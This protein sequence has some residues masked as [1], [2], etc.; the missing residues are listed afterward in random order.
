VRCEFTKNQFKQIAGRYSGLVGAK[1]RYF[2]K[3]DKIDYSVSAALLYDLDNFTADAE[4]PNKE[5]LRISIR[6]KF[7][8]DLTES[9]RFVT[10]I[11]YK[12]NLVNFND[13]IM[14]SNSN[15]NFRIF[16]HVLLRI[17]YEHEYNSRPATNR[18][19]KT[20]ALLL[21]GFGIEL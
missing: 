3:P 12:P 17:S 8:H 20:D 4:L 11:Y 9:I 1:Y 14:Y 2:V 6:P 5:R 21:A 13:F 18:V 7:K 15:I 19:R 16:K 10:E